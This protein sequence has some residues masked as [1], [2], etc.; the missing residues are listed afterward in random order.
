MTVA[1]PEGFGWVI[2]DQVGA[3][4][5]PHKQ[6]DAFEFFHQMG[7]RVVVTLDEVPLSPA[8]IE[9]FGIE[10]HHISIEDFCAPTP[11][12]IEEF[13][14]V[15]THAREAGKKLAVHCRAGRGRTGTM[16]ACYLVNL[17]R[18]AKKALAEIRSLRPG[19]VETREQE[20]AVHAY[21]RRL[22]GEN[23]R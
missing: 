2:P 15:A 8:M 3:M 4:A 18:L 5:W 20:K 17:G 11:E 19:S 13:V 6:H 21:E 10:Y 1:P 23:K 16:L 14:G 22:R 7:I 9:E 12:Q